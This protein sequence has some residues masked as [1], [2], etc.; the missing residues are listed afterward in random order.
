MTQASAGFC[1]R[2]ADKVSNVDHHTISKF[3][4]KF[5]GYM[6]VLDQLKKIREALL[7]G[8]GRAPA[9]IEEPPNV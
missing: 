1:G 6:P 2:T 4:T 5:G 7:E 8:A 3:D 9:M